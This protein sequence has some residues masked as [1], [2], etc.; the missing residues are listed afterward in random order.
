MSQ[1]LPVNDFKWVKDISEFNEN[2]IKSY[3]DEIDEVYFLEVDVQ[4]PENL[5]N[6]HK[7][8]P[9]LPE[10]TKM[11]KVEKLVANLYDKEEYVIHIENLKQALEHGKVLK[12]MHKIHKYIK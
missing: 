6:L 3:I 1:K 7:F 10:K 2:F 4:Y 9:I 8:L 12:K 5:C 11:D